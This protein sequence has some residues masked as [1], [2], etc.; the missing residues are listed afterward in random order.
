[1]RLA[2]DAVDAQGRPVELEFLPLHWLIENPALGQIEQSTWLRILGIGSTSVIADLAGWRSDTVDLV[3]L[4]LL[5]ERREPAFVEDWRAGIRQRR[6]RAFGT[7]VP[8][9][10]ATGAPEGGGVFVNRGD[11]FFASGAVTAT[12]FELSDGLVVE[13]DARLRFTRKLHQIFVV[14]LHLDP[15][16]DSTLEASR[17]PALLELRVVG[18]AGDR[19]DTLALIL[20]GQREHL[21]MPDGVGLWHRYALQ[22]HPDGIVELLVDDRMYWRSPSRLTL[23]RNAAAFLVIGG[24]SYETELALGPVRV[25]RGVKFRLPELAT[26]AR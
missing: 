14:A 4:P 18:P 19:P 9:T 12:P 13:F 25:Y 7:P 17:P 21:P 15:L 6:W 24:Q 1:V 20:A 5:V 10:R 16:P 2:A 22:V 3:A 26:P 23:P 8:D 11:E